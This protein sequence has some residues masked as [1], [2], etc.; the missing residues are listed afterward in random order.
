[1]NFFAEY[2]GCISEEEYS[3]PHI[4]P[5]G[6]LSVP[7]SFKLSVNSDPIIESRKSV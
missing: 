5:T 6:T 1:M 4:H 7:D 3:R 2:N